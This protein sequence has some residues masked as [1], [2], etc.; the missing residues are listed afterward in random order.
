MALSVVLL[1]LAIR[2]VDS[3]SPSYLSLIKHPFL[4]RRMADVIQV[5]TINGL[6]PGP[7][8][9]STNNDDIYINVLN[10][11]DEPLLM[12]CLRPK[13]PGPFPA[14]QSSLDCLFSVNQ[15]KSFNRSNPQGTFNVTHVTI[16]QTFMPLTR[17]RLRRLCSR[18][19]L[20]R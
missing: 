11:L 20:V 3:A 13:P 17:E 2:L 4:A 15:A 18:K 1:L 14:G 6:F 16:S 19:S 8:I 7:L 9:N 12:T 5:T 10:N